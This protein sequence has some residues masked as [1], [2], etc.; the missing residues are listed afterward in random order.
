[1]HLTRRFS[2]RAALLI[3]LVVSV[4]LLSTRIQADTAFCGG[5]FITVPFTDVAGNLFF[6]SIAEA[7]FSGLTNGTTPTTYSPNQNVPRDQMAAFITRTLDQSLKRGSQRAV[8]DQNWTIQTANN[9][10]STTVLTGPL[11]VRSD[12]TDLWVAN[13]GSHAV[14]RVRASDGKLLDTWTGATDAHGVLCAMGKVFV[15]GASS[16]DGKLYQIDPKQTAGAV[17]T[18]SSGLDEGPRG[19]AFDGQRIW[20]AN[21]G[22]SVSIITLNP[23][24][25]TNVTT[26]FTFPNGLVYDGTNIWVT[27]YLDGKVKKLD[28]NGSILT[29][30]FIGN[31]PNHPAFD[32]IN[33]WVPNNLANTVSVVRALGALS[34]TVLAT[35]TG[36]GLNGPRQAAFDGE[37]ILVTNDAD[38]V[39]LWKASD[40]S[41][42]GTF[43]TG[44]STEPWGACSDGINFWI[45][46]RLVNKLARF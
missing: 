40:L 45:T 2:V 23:I 32:G 3:S 24:I 20:T 22:G 10:T 31:G 26:G 14:S 11:L 27:D 46:F 33:I 43:P 13:N 7:Y 28:S 5:Q 44:V 6:C 8:L 19:I 9:L 36:N 16:P 37:R 15:T 35:L 18:L 1:M 39:S 21:S 17:T 42:I 4:T 30:I 12:G 38:S 41:P 34:G 25:V 29:S